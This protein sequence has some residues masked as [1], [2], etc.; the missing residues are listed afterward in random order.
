MNASNT[1]LYAKVIL[2]L[3][4]DGDFTYTVPENLIAQVQSG[5]RVLVPFGAR[6]YYTGVVSEVTNIAPPPGVKL[7]E[8][9]S[10]LDDKPIIRNPQLRFWRWIADYYLCTVGDVFKAALPSG[11]K[12]ESETRVEIN[13]DALPEAFAD[14]DE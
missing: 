10:V 9:L 3:P 5:H 7:K 8:I 2:P 4:L 1:K 11:L 6:H 13:P 14:V 12:V